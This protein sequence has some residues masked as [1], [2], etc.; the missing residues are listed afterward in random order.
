[1]G[2]RSVYAVKPS[3]AH[4]MVLP[5]HHST[6]QQ[7]VGASWAPKAGAQAGGQLQGPCQPHIACSP[8]A[9]WPQVRSPGMLPGK[10]AH[11]PSTHLQSC[12][13]IQQSTSDAALSPGHQSTC[14]VLGQERWP[15]HSSNAIIPQPPSPRTR[16]VCTGGRQG[17]PHRQLQGSAQ[18][19]SPTSLHLRVRLAVV[20]R[21]QQGQLLGVLLQGR[22]AK[23]RSVAAVP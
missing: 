3:V 4:G 13:R 8:A 6:A 5:A 2:S 22:G 21:L 1:M 16:E 12:R 23:R 10:H 7:Q 15:Q 9:Q 20:Q 19:H 14:S 11:N 17:T 18:L